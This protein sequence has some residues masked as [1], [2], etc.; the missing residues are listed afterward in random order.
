MSANGV[1]TVSTSNGS[2]PLCMALEHQH[3]RWHKN[4]SL[5]FIRCRCVQRC[6]E[7]L[8]VR[9]H[10]SNGQCCRPV[11]D[12]AAVGLREGWPHLRFKWKTLCRAQIAGPDVNLR[13][14]Q[15]LLGHTKIDSTGR[16]LLRS[17]GQK[18]LNINKESLD[19]TPFPVLKR[20]SVVV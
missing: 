20:H 1:T 11:C 17:S 2:S 9:R 4:S 12:P 6:S 16:Y 8:R 18:R 19:Y 3:R 14:V 15:L 13:A 7:Y 10:G 5:S